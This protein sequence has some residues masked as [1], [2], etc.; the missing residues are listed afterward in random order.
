MLGGVMEQPRRLYERFIDVAKKHLFRRVLNPYNIPLLISGDVRVTGREDDI[1]IVNTARG[2][3][4]TCFVGGMVG[5]GARIL[6]G[7]KT[8]TSPSS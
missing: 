5:L 6:T 4:L 2:Q 3:H 1:T 8:W 7:K